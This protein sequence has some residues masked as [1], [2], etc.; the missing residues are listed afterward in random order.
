MRIP[1]FAFK[2]LGVCTIALLF[3]V[4]QARNYDPKIGR[5]L[6]EDPS[7]GNVARPISH[8]NKYVYVENDPMNMI[9]PFGSSGIKIHG[10]WCGPDYGIEGSTPRDQLDQ[11]CEIHDEYTG[12]SLR[13]S[14]PNSRRINRGQADMKLSLR[15]FW[16]MPGMMGPNP[17]HRPVASAYGTYKAADV[18]VTMGGLGMMQVGWGNFLMGSQ[19]GNINPGQIVGGLAL[20]YVGAHIFAIGVAYAVPVALIENSPRIGREVRRFFKRF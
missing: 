4:A 12:D 9:D 3:Q 6:Q 13:G 2:V 11:A 14:S 15:A 10:N 7:D 20:A 17:G 19:Q 1:C 8:I 5:F 18:A 16:S